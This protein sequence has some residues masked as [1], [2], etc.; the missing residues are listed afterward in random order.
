MRVIIGICIAAVSAL[1]LTIIGVLVSRL[2]SHEE[3]DDVHP[4]IMDVNDPYIKR[5]EWLWVIP[6]YLGEPISNHPKWVTQ[7][8][9]TGKKIGLHGVYHTKHEFG[10]ERSNKY[11]D[12]GVK[13]F[14][15]AFGYPPAHFKAPG[16]ALTY[17]NRK[18]IESRGME[19]KGWWNQICHRVHHSPKGRLRSGWLIGE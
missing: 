7:L 3:L 11:I 8:K 17:G 19:V 6:F 2:V 10:V 4:F 1:V 14:H 12:K 18:K 13:E 5:S 15:K 9:E 16:L